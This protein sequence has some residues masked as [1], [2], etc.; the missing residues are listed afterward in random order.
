[1]VIWTRSIEPQTWQE[2]V[3]W[4]RQQSKDGVHCHYDF[5]QEPV[6]RAAILFLGIVLILPLAATAKT[7]KVRGEGLAPCIAWVQEHD[8][9]SNRQHVQDSWLLGYVNAVSGMLE[10]PGVEDVSGPFHNIDLVMWIDDYC[11][12]HPEEPIVRAADALM[13]DLARRAQ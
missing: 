4:H 8:R 3:P 2:Q 9:K 5:G 1:V 13:R 12:S 6:M 11:S 10:I 7:I